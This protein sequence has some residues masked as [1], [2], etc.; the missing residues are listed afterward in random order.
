MMSTQAITDEDHELEQVFKRLA[1]EFD[2]LEDYEEILGFNDRLQKELK[3]EESIGRYNEWSAERYT[4]RCRLATVANL[5]KRVL[6]FN[7]M[8]ANWNKRDPEFENT[9]SALTFPGY[10][11]NGGIFGLGPFVEVRPGRGETGGP[12]GEARNAGPGGAV[13]AAKGETKRHGKSR[14]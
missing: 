11:P 3:S 7:L 5:S 10:L 6:R 12:P 14:Q 8:H 4:Q 2:K 1:D 9:L 13:G